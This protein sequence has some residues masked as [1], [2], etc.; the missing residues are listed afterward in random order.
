[1][2]IITIEYSVY[3]NSPNILISEYDDK[4]FQLIFKT[5]Y[6]SKLFDSLISNNKITF[7]IKVIVLNHLMSQNK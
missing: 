2:I 7:L 3:N 6:I 1:M 4:S 5:L